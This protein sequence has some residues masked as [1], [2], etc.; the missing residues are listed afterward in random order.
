MNTQ[1]NPARLWE[2]SG[3]TKLHIAVTF[4]FLLAN[5]MPYYTINGVRRRVATWNG[6]AGFLPTAA[7][8]IA[9]VTAILVIVLV[10]TH[11]PQR[12]GHHVALLV[13]YSLLL[14]VVVASGFITP[15]D[16]WQRADIAR[17]SY[18]LGRSVGFYLCLGAS[19]AAFVACVAQLRRYRTAL[20]LAPSE[21]GGM[22]P[23]FFADEPTAITGGTCLPEQYPVWKE[24]QD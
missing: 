20:G 23:V 22:Y 14:V 5:F 9:L 11:R 21:P 12:M 17:N 18:W 19:L 6:T 7:F 13:C 24:G 3:T 16:T 15:L 1:T 10:S 4:V 8:V 2:H